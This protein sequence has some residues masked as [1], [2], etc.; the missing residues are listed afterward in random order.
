MKYSKSLVAALVIAT[1]GMTTSCDFSDFGDINTTPNY[2]TEGYTYMLFQYASMHSRNFI[3]TSSTYDP[4]G[5]EWSGY[6]SEAKNNQ[7]GSFA[8]TNNFS[9]GG[10]YTGPIKNLT[11][12]IEAN[13]NEETKDLLS[14]TTFGSNAN[15]I[16]VATTLRAFYYMSISDI[17]GPIVYSEA[18]KAS[19]E[20]FQPKFDK[21]ADV[22]A[23]L[24]KELCDVYDLFDTSENLNQPSADIFFGGNVAKWKKFNATLR[25]MLAIK[26]ADVDPATGKARFAKAY[27]DGGMESVDDSFCY[28]FD[29]SFANA[30]FYA[31][32]NQGYASRGLGF[33]PNKI[34]IEALKEYRDPRLFTYAT[35]GID[36]FAYLGSRP[37]ASEK[38]FDAYF[39]IPNGLESNS[40][41]GAAMAIA[42]SVAPKYCVQ[43]ATYGLITTARCK[44]VEAEA[45][46]RG[47]ISADAATLY[48]EGIQASFDF[49]ASSDKEFDPSQATDYIAAHPLP[50]ATDE[51]LKEIVMQRFLAGFLTDG[52]E[53]WADWRRF[54]IPTFPME[55]G[56]VAEG[57]D[58]YPQRLEFSSFDYSTNEANVKAILSDLSN[59]KDDRWSRVWWDVADNES[60]IAE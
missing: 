51:A 6:L 32:G 23:G 47:W 56:Q 31:I 54:N 24:D 26:L 4:W 19:E 28:T 5:Q 60:P 29:V 46:A 16:A 42:C 41:V 11:A 52:I 15:Q 33:G 1:S 18:L 10:Y 53:S 34:F 57:H 39:G 17:T 20:N 48:A 13:T 36:K 38:D 44:L 14:T 58:S 45:A 22:Y 25:M 49:E 35:I 55:A 30:W 27:A 3:M 12:I 7:Y 2:P 8:T 21:Q 9:A 59:G 50:A 43:T 37:G 40:A